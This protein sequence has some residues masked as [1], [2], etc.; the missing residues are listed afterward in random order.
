M[1]EK[2][3]NWLESR[4]IN[5]LLYIFWLL[6]KIIRSYSQLETE[7]NQEAAESWRKVDHSFKKPVLRRSSSS[8]PS[9]TSDTIVGGGGPRS[10][11]VVQD[12][13]PL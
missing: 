9:P 4:K 2:Q 13:D 1:D 7:F 11:V 3:R 8:T 10:T 5:Q 12:D 6:A